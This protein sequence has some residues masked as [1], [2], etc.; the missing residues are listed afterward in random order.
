MI[1]GDANEEADRALNYS[2]QEKKDPEGRC[3]KMRSSKTAKWGRGDKRD[4][5]KNGV[6]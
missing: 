4:F 6:R 3:K 2:M 5:K 1:G